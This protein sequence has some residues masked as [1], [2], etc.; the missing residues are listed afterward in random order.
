[1]KFG[2]MIAAL[3]ATTAAHA[4]DTAT[5]SYDWSGA[6]IGIQA[7][8]RWAETDTQARGNI[9]MAPGAIKPEGG[10][11]GSYAGYNFQLGGIVIGAEAGVI[12]N[13]ISSYRDIG[14]NYR[15]KDSAKTLASINARLG[16]AIDRTLIYGS[17]GY[18]RARYGSE[19][20]KDLTVESYSNSLNGYNIG[21]GA[22]YAFTD[23][24]IG[25]AEYRYFNFGK[26]KFEHVLFK[27]RQQTAVLGL[28]YK[29]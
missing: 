13:T 23:N 26:Q 4:A 3:C 15:I 21:I 18:T 14:D 9:T 6:Y 5:S 17:A 22:E 8:G 29:F 7:G 10:L 20:H 27:Y 25:R 16:Y 28:A 1:M 24:I 19:H 2:I 11:L 12:I